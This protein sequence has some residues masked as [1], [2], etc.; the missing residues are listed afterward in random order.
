MIEHKC[1][2]SLRGLH[3]GACVARTI[4]SYRYTE[5]IGAHSTNRR[6]SSPDSNR[7]PALPLL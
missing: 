6:C 5:A 7:M 2:V 4:I 1:V 3:H